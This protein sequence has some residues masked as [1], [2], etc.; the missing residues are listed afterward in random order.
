MAQ[1]TSNTQIDTINILSEASSANDSDMFLLQRGSISYKIPKNKLILP[2]SQITGLQN[3]IPTGGNKNK[4]INGNFDIWQRGLIN[5]RPDMMMSGGIINV[6]RETCGSDEHFNFNANWYQRIQTDT[7][8]NEPNQYICIQDI[9]NT[10]EILGK[11]VTLSFW[12]RAGEPT[13]I[14]SE[15]QI[16]GSNMWTPTITKIFNL[17]TSWQKFTHTYTMPTYQ[18][19][20]DYCYDPDLVNISNPTYTPLK[21][22]NSVPH[23]YHWYY[24]I[25]LKAV[26]DDTEWA[27]HGNHTNRPVGYFYNERMTEAQQTAFKAAFVDNNEIDIAQIQLEEG[28]VATDFEHRPF[29]EELK[30]CQRYYFNSAMYLDDW[31]TPGSGGI[32]SNEIVFQRDPTVNNYWWGQFDFPTQMINHPTVTIWCPQN[33]ENNP[34]GNQYGLTCVYEDRYSYVSTSKSAI[35]TEHG[36]RSLKMIRIDGAPS[37][38]GGYDNVNKAPAAFHVELDS[39]F[40]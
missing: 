18:Q 29:S 28:S 32:N 12:A 23:L 36:L 15:S 26:W 38:L 31:I 22:S 37:N 21:N 39:G 27:K 16:S 19:V 7:Y 13:Q 34:L 8:S 33:S 14:L 35:K 20:Y 24:Q 6:S 4:V 1:V 11:T 25:D 2:S 30:R 10:S 9:E 40:S 5:A 17:T 3:A